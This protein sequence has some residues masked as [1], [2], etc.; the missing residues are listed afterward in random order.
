MNKTYLYILFTISFLF[1]LN[2]SN[3][4]LMQDEPFITGDDGV[5]RM[6]V[7]IIGHVNTPGT[8]LVYDNI[9]LMSA[10]S[11]AGGYSPG[12]NLKNLRI[13]SKDG[14]SKIINLRKILNSDLSIK[15]V[16][17]LKPHDTIHIEQKDLHQFFVSSNLPSM[18]LS[19]IT[20]AITLEDK[21]G[22]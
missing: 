1:S 7:N 5:I 4:Y 3:S 11:I 9:D 13:Y 22:N 16:V 17:D 21:N 19:F 6:Y 14:S 8:Y 20:L 2:S 18:I 10:I 15:K 12:A